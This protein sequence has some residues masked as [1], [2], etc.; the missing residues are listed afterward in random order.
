M[1]VRFVI[2]KEVL[3]KDRAKA[4]AADHNDVKGLGITLRAA[5]GARGVSVGAA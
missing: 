4:A 5:I 2:G 1:A 3:G